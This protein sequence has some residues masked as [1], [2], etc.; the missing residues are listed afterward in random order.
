MIPEKATVSVIRQ[1]SALPEGENYDA[2]DTQSSSVLLIP[3]P[4]ES[5]EDPLVCA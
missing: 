4:S 2:S 1:G 5:A 3:K